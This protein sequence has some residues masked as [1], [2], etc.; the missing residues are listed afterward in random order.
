MMQSGMFVAAE[1]FRASVSAGVFT[2]Y[3]REEDAAMKSGKLDE[4]LARMSAIADAITPGCL[5][6]C[7]QRPS[8]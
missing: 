1:S 3:R 6:L 2:H 5:L 4:E 7:N 8:P